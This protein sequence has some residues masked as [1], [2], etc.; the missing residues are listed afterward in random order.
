MLKENLFNIFH[1]LCNKN[2]KTRLSRRV[3]LML[4]QPGHIL[5][6]MMNEK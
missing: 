4:V 5:I 6:D 2:G 3:F 1:L